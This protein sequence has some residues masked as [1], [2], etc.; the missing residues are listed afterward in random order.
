MEEIVPFLLLLL[1]WQVEQPRETMTVERRLMMSE[2]ACN[3]EGAEFEAQREI[4]KEEFKGRAF[5][6][7]CVPLP[8]QKEF[9]DMIET[10]K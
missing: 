3:A 1:G 7:F 8:N 2:N 5:R 6:Y 9:Q 10:A 4:Y